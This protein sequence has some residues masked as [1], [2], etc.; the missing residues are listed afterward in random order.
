MVF[1]IIGSRDESYGNQSRTYGTD[2]SLRVRVVDRM[3]DRYGV[4][5]TIPGVVF[6]YDQEQLDGAR[7]FAI[8]RGKTTCP[9]RFTTGR[10]RTGL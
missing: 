9:A 6:P 3:T 7:E 4:Y 2:G 1:F 10:S 8:I 5:I